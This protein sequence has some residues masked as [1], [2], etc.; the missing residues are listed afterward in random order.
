MRLETLAD[1]LM[2]YSL[3]CKVPLGDTLLM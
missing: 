2:R 1:L 3:L